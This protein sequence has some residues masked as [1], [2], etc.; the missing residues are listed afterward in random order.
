MNS[1]VALLELDTELMKKLSSK[2]EYEETFYGLGNYRPNWNQTAIRCGDVHMCVCVCLFQHFGFNI[3]HLG[4][5]EKFLSEGSAIAIDFFFGDYLKDEKWARNQEKSPDGGLSWFEEYRDGLFLSM[6]SEN[7]EAEAKLTG[8]IEPWL[9]RDESSY[10]VTEHEN[11]YHKLLAEYLKFG[12]IK[13]QHLREEFKSCRKK[14]PKLLYACLTALLEK[15]PQS[16]SA[17]LSKFLDHYLKSDFREAITTYFSIEASILCHIAK[18]AGIEPT[19]LNEKQTAL[20]ITRET[21]GLAG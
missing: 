3:A 12:E 14:R 13:S 20:I 10:L 7:T 4:T 21:L 9:P 11:H 8:W 16:F 18:R 17:A 15:D 1:F 2:E 19:G 6:I 5:L